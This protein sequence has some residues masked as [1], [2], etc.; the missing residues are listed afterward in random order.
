MIHA[1]TGSIE[2]ISGQ[3]IVISTGSLEY[4][5]HVSSLTASQLS[6]LESE[7]RN[8]IRILTY[9]HHKEDAMTLFGFLSHD[10]RELFK[11]LIKVQGIGPKQAI[12]ILSGVTVKDFIIALDTSDVTALTKIPG[13]GAK[14]AQK[15][16]LALRNKISL[17]QLESGSITRESAATSRFSELQQALVEM[18]YDKKMVKKVVEELLESYDITQGTSHSKIEETVFKQAIIK[19]G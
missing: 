9:L 2:E 19:L 15:I 12:K 6:S 8:N 13:L 4:I 1:V 17:T 7:E 18:G 11:E 3:Q 10:E 14:T 16:L 5:L